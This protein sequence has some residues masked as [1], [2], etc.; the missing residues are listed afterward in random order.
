MF[1]LR[2][3]SFIDASSSS[4]SGSYP[5]RIISTVMI[6]A[7]KYFLQKSYSLIYRQS[8]TMAT[9]RSA[10]GQNSMK[11]LISVMRWRA[12]TPG[13]M[14]RANLPRATNTSRTLGFNSS[15]SVNAISTGFLL[16]S[17]MS[18]HSRHRAVAVLSNVAN[19]N[20]STRLPLRSISCKRADA[21]VSF[22]ALATPVIKNTRGFLSFVIVIILFIL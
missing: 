21:K 15:D 22:P 11:P 13:S 17:L 8:E 3:I 19:L 6:V 1:S 20:C 18:S 10:F 5:G 4:L 14:W 7:S 2:K 16:S 12:K 9:G